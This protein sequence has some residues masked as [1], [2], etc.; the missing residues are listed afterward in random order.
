MTDKNDITILCK[1]V[2]NY[3]DIGFVYRLAR[4]LTE[5]NPQLKLRL[6]VSDLPSF[7]AMAPQ[8]NPKEQ[9]QKSGNLEIFD[10][11][12]D[13]IC[14]DHFTQYPPNIILE[15]FQCGR[16]DWLEK[17]LFENDLN[18]IVQIL[19]IDYLTAEPYAEEFHC[20]KSATRSIYVK[21]V[22]FMPGF[23]DKTGGLILD[24]DFIENKHTLDPVH[25]VQKLNSSIT[26]LDFEN[27]DFYPVSIFS[28]ERNFDD[29]VYTLSQF[30]MTKRINHPNFKV[31]AFVAAGKSLGP[32]LTAW[33]TFQRPFEITQ[34]P[35]LE[36]K[37]WDL[38]L[39]LCKFNFIRGED[40]LSRACLAGVP[41]VWHA[42]EQDDDYQLV[43]VQALLNR[44]QKHFDNED[45]ENL[46]KLMISYNNPKKQIDRNA[47]YNLLL[48]IK[49]KPCFEDFSSELISNGNLAQKLVNY[50]DQLN[51]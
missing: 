50:I 10:W 38:L 20:L 29:I 23:T 49:A 11:N 14:T 21:K 22:N 5:V 43:K 45:F 2:D 28:Y 48:S 34:L 32:F 33:N 37:L 4:S 6:I 41:F 12:S 17:I 13:Q 35:F 40:S 39:C 47:L 19:N 8:I 24:N 7:S 36:Q 26:A 15:C 1:V 25:L 9:Y 46:S 16:P 3:G 18:H 51:L 44:M 30:Q 27:P 42:Y 31:H